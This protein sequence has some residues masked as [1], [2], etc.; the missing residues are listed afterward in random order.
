MY[1]QEWVQSLIDQIQQFLQEN[2][3]WLGIEADGSQRVLDYACGN[4]TV[5]RVSSDEL[6]HLVPAILTYE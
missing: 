5:S 2:Y 6:L 4:G 1:C 3:E